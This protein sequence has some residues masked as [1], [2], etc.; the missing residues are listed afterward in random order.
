VGHIENTSCYTFSVV[1]CTHFRRCLEMGL[2]VTVY[3]YIYIKQFCQLFC[4]V[5][6]VVSYFEKIVWIMNVWKQDSH[7]NILSAD[8]MK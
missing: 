7:E 4:W 8:A 3:I 6:N 5:W 1:A 2:H